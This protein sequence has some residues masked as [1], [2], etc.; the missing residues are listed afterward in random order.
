[1]AG[2]DG[3]EQQE[4]RLSIVVLYHNQNGTCSCSLSLPNKIYCEENN[5]QSD[6]G[7]QELAIL[8]PL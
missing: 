4:G 6:A 5:P 8:L 1:M 2:S 7:Q 3:S